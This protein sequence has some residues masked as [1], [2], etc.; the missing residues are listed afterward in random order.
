MSSE[1]PQPTMDQIL[2]EKIRK[3]IS[4]NCKESTITSEEVNEIV[5]ELKKE[6]E[7]FVAKT[8]KKHFKSLAEH[9]LKT[10]GDWYA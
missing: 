9:I 2:E 8:I 3:I 10:M 7:G 5:G 1:K 6:M 4:E